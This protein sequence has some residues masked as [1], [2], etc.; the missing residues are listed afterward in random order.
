MNELWFLNNDLILNTHTGSGKSMVF[1]LSGYYF[2]QQKPLAVN[3]TVLVILPLLAIIEDQVKELEQ[4]GFS[5]VQLSSEVL[6]SKE[7]PKINE[8]K[9]D[10]IFVTPEAILSDDSRDHFEDVAN[11]LCLIVIVECHLYYKG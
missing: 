10:F 5:C 2:R 11:A 6:L 1:I 8:G 3:H 4:L 7:A 9:Y